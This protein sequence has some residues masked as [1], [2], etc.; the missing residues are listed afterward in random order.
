M[1]HFGILCLS[2]RTQKRKDQ[3]QQRGADLSTRVTGP[4]PRLA[5]THYEGDQQTEENDFIV[6]TVY[7]QYPLDHGPLKIFHFETRLVLRLCERPPG[8]KYIQYC[9]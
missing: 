3:K 8:D 6:T 2:T 9:T 5:S 7:S 1:E 4:H